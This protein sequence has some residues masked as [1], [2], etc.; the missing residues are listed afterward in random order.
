MA[1]RISPQEAKSLMDEGY[2]YVDVRSTPEFEEGHPAGAHHVPLL[3]AGPAGMQPNPDFVQ[4]MVDRYPT[5]AK[6]ILGCRS[7]GRS[8]RAAAMLEQVGFKNLVDQRAGFNGAGDPSGQIAEPGWAAAGL[9][10]ETGRR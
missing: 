6:L 3:E 5:D 2:T 8:A 9:P 1:R 7:G 10:I 4:Q